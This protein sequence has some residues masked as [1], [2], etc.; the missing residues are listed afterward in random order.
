MLKKQNDRIFIKE[1]TTTA[2][3]FHLLAEAFESICRDRIVH[4]LNENN[5]Q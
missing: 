4:D 5:K 2:L 1:A 3:F